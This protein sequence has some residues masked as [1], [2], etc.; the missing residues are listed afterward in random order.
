LKPKIAYPGLVTQINLLS[1]N[2]DLLNSL[3]SSFGIFTSPRGNFIKSSTPGFLLKNN[4]KKSILK[5][6][7]LLGLKTQILNVEERGRH[8]ALPHRPSPNCLNIAWGKNLFADPP[9]NLP[10]AT[11]LSDED[12]E[13]ITFFARTEFHN[14]DAIFGIKEGEDRRRHTYII[15]KSG[16]GKNYLNR[17]HGHR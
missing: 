5:R 10:V 14:Q 3:S 1:N 6:S 7:F 13:K 16:T 2:P 15:G 11:N 8:V 4:L 17:Q 9:E 12:K